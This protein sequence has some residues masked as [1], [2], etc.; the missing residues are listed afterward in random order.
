VLT[1]ERA[2][3]EW[4]V[5]GF[6]LDFID[7]F[8][9]REEDV[10]GGG[11]D[12]DSVVDALE[13]TLVEVVS[14]IRTRRRDAAIEFRQPSAGPLM[15]MFANMLRA[16]DCP[17]DA[18]ENRVRTLTL[19]LLAGNTPVHSDM[20]TW[21]PGDAVES[22][23][24]QLL[25]V[26]FAVPQISVRL[27]RLPPEQL[28]MPRFWLGFWR[29][30]RDVLLD[31]RLRPLHPDLNY[32]LVFAEG[33]DRLVGAVYG[34]GLVLLPDTPPT[35][36]V[37]NATGSNRVVLELSAPLERALTVRDCTGRIVREERLR[38]DSGLLAVAVP[39]SGLLELRED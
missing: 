10:F 7:E 4:G 2:V 30:H 22:A 25:N 11:R 29:E 20:L 21:Y 26:L 18:L 3:K 36:F 16:F 1:Y 19:R 9:L 17:N 12:M 27:D 6:K 31:G 15:R 8:Q 13:T 23:A 14:R 35:A 38:L 34:E 24:S 28:A 37:V 5:D 33:D 39:R 32:P